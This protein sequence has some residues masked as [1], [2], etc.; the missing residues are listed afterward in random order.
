MPDNTPIKDANNL[1]VQ[2]ATDELADGSQSPKVT[3]LAGDGT[4]TAISP[5]TSNLQQSAN[6]L[7]GAVNETAPAGDT[8]SS[9][10]NG[11]LQRVAQRI[12]SLIALLP[13]SLGGKTSANSLAVTIAT[14]D[15][16]ISRVGDVVASPTANTILAR[17]KAIVDE[18]ANQSFAAGTAGASSSDV[19]S[20]QGIASMTPLIVDGG[21]VRI[22]NVNPT[23]DT[24]AYVA[25]DVLFATTEVTSAVR[26]NDAGGTLMSM[27]IIDQD[28]QKQ[29]MVIYVLQTNV[30]LG[31]FNAAPNITDA[32]SLNLLGRVDIAAGDWTD[33]GGTAV[34]SLRNLNIPIQPSSGTDDIFIAAVTLGTPT[35]T[36]SG[37]RVRI[38][39]VQD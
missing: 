9:G 17:L 5:A 22:I 26:A 7:T 3:L 32:N 36:A 1:T 15:P 19:L 25:G 14:D 13:T 38:G 18:L 27:T 34:C 4:T 30:A 16:L 8:N 12:T 37:I 35:H 6:T 21:R 20:V 10:L 31:T 24:S 23:L 39:I 28:D 11:R 2:A 33:L 29:G